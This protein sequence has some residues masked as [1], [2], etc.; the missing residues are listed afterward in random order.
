MIK[1]VGVT[2]ARA[3]LRAILSELRESG[4]PVIL[5]RDSKPEAVI[6][7]YNE[8]VRSQEQAQA[9]WNLRFEAA[10]RK[11]HAAF[12]QWLQAQGRDPDALSEEEILDLIRN[13]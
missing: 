5:A 13:A 2:E 12:R 9:L 8:Y 7:P 10:L 6:I 1:I 3:R 4:Q 11:S